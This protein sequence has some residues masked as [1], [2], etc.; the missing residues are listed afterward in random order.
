LSKDEPLEST[1]CNEGDCKTQ[2]VIA[3][4]VQ[5]MTGKPILKAGRGGFYSPTRT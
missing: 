1:P 4:L 3:E 5:A 2:F